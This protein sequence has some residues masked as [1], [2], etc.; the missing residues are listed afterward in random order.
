[1]PY[2]SLMERIRAFQESRILLTAIE[3][4]LFTAVGEG[5]TAPELAGKLDTDSRAT[6][7]LLNALVALGMLTK[8]DSVF[9]NAPIATRHLT[10]GSPENARAALMHTV[11]LWHR[12]STLT[13]CVRTGTAIHHEEI[14]GRSEEWILAFIAAMHRNAVDRAPYVVMAVGAEHARR[15]LDIGGGSGAYSIAFAEAN[16]ALH[17]E[18]LDLSEVLPIAQENIASAG[19]ADRIKTRA[20][21]LRTDSFGEG[22]DLAFISAICHMLG[23]AENLDLL[24]RSFDSLK[25][26]GR[27]AIQDFI[28]EA[29]KTGPRSGAIFALNM[30]V[31]TPNGSSYSEKEYRTWLSEAGFADVNQV[32]LPGPTDLMVATRK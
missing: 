23:P 14:G 4:D 10:E 28:L 5:I 31:G 6:E 11:H 1:V 21:D 22:Y 27:V 24:R 30:L 8:K 12:W 32:W 2:D 9:R 19:L 18:V 15:M 3:L 16:P 20:C 7:M 26:G 17:A 13:E 29:D 25:P